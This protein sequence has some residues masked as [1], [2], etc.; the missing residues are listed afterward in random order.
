MWD[1]APSADALLDVRVARGWRPRAT[2]LRDGPKILGHAAARFA[3]E[4]L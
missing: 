1:H 4:S 2:A 3:A